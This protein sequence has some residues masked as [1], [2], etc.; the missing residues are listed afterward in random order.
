MAS[1]AEAV[2]THLS[3]ALAKGEQKFH[4]HTLLRCELRCFYATK[5]K[6]PLTAAYGAN[7]VRLVTD[8]ERGRFCLGNA[9]V[10]VDG[11]SGPFGH[12]AQALHRQ[13][14]SKTRPIGE[15]LHTRV[16]VQPC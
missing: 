16:E 8:A 7:S 14:A 10:V 1:V 11:L 9:L 12:T 3:K 5:I 6:N 15:W 4:E 13:I 2:I